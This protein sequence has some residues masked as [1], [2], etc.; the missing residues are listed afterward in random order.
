MNGDDELLAGLRDA[1]KEDRDEGADGPRMLG[2]DAEARIASRLTP[3]LAKPPATV[4]ALHPRRHRRVVA[5]GACVLAIAAAAMLTVRFRASD[6]ALP[7]YEVAVVGGEQT[8]RGVAVPAA[9]AK[10]KVRP[11][12]EYRVV[13]RPVTRSPI[14]VESRAFVSQNGRV[15]PFAGTVDVAEGGSV[16]I[17][18]TP[19][20]IAQLAPGEARLVIF[21]GSADFLP[22]TID[23]APSPHVARFELVV[24]VA[25]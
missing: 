22:V 3:L 23:Q 8:S 2:P 17:V 25:N 19:T 24:E 5:F 4:T 1:A 12:G 10:I 16:R 9:V 14:A 21:V 11:G 13:L 18:A 7:A 20:E 15:R 6:M